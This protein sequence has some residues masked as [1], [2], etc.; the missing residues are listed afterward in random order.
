MVYA[1]LSVSGTR[2]MSC[3]G[4][5]VLGVYCNRYMLQSVLTHHHG[6]DR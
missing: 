2:C 6:M 4:C 1:V 3:F 5:A